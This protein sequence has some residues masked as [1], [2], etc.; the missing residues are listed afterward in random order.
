MANTN[1]LRNCTFAWPAQLLDACTRWVRTIQ[2]ACGSGCND[3]MNTKPANHVINTKPANSTRN[4]AEKIQP[5]VSNFTLSHTHSTSLLVAPS[6]TGAGRRFALQ[7]PPI[8]RCEA[9]GGSSRKKRLH[10]NPLLSC[11]PVELIGA[12][13]GGWTAWSLSLRVITPGRRRRGDA[14]LW[15]S[16][17]TAERRAMA[18]DRPSIAKSGN[19]YM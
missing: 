16:A 14:A 5:P 17:R 15:A 4:S 12:A 2:A 1:H 9:G 7:I 13:S 8:F 3:V 10:S 18:T 11:S 19:S 6:C